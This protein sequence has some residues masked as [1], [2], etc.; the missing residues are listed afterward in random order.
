[1]DEGIATFCRQEARAAIIGGVMPVVALAILLSAQASA[2][3]VWRVGDLLV[4]TNNGQYK[5]VRVTGSGGSATFQV[6]DTLND[7]TSNFTA[8]C[9]FDSD[10]R[11]HAV[12]F[13]RS[14]APRLLER[15]QMNDIGVPHPVIVSTDTS[16]AG[17]AGLTGKSIALDAQGSIY[18][19]HSAGTGEIDQ[20]IP[21]APGAPLVNGKL[22]F[23]PGTQFPV[24]ANVDVAG[25][26]WLDVTSV[27]AATPSQLNPYVG[28]T[29]SIYYTSAGPNIYLLSFLTN[30]S[31]SPLPTSPGTIQKLT[32]NLLKFNP[33]KGFAYHGIKILADASGNPTGLVVAAGPK[34][35]LFSV[36]GTTATLSTVY[37]Y[38]KSSKNTNWESVSLEPNGGFWVTDRGNQNLAHFPVM[39]SAAGTFIT[40]VP[41]T[42]L[43]V[44]TMIGT[45][46]GICVDGSF[47]PGQPKLQPALTA[48]LTPT[49]PPGP[50]WLRPSM[51][52]AAAN[53]SS[54]RKRIPTCCLRRSA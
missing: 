32:I 28:Y 5:F 7:G 36:S 39:F 23:A 20:Y 15:Y 13:A 18:V 47:S 19:A 26:E 46:S 33:P 27:A 35:V 31:N 6:V 54:S 50:R 51:C 37:D 22:G 43:A 24:G 12:G 17:L 42:T 45:P 41:D 38:S 29:N 25:S 52:G 30:P 4:A 2:G 21:P 44:G 34:V 53:L 1:M 49:T 8:G 16:S 11:P 14:H 48:T 9:S 10:L 3:D 40:A